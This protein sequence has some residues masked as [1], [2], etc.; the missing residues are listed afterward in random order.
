MSPEGYWCR[1]APRQSGGSGHARF[2]AVV[3]GDSHSGDGTGRAQRWAPL[4]QGDCFIQLLDCRSSQQI[5]FF[6]SAP[7]VIYSAPDST[8]VLFYGAELRRIPENPQ[9][10]PQHYCSIH[11]DFWQSFK[12]GTKACLVKWNFLYITFTHITYNITK[13]HLKIMPRSNYFGNW[14]TI[15]LSMDVPA[16]MSM[17]GCLQ[18]VQNLPCST[19]NSM[20]DTDSA[21]TT[22]LMSITLENSAHI[23]CMSGCV[24]WKWAG[25]L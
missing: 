20:T 25:A 15:K 23:A 16:L 2:T 6:L 7:A 22:T 14:H 11:Q 13:N 21:L 12:R 18:Y 1:A 4:P 17:N 9:R 8:A 19:L 24:L 10:Y 5:T 3:V